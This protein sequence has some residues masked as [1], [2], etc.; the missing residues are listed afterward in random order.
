M[1]IGGNHGD[2]S[3]MAAA[4][5]L[6]CKTRGCRPGQHRQVV[7]YRDFM[8]LIF[9]MTDE[10]VEPMVGVKIKGV[11]AQTLPACLVVDLGVILLLRFP[12]PDQ[13]RQTT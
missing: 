9:K 7:F 11:T 12:A 1:N 10:A 13:Q 5:H 2:F 6:W 4:A 3:G 8:A